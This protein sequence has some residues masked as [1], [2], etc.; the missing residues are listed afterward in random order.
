MNKRILIF[1]FNLIEIALALVIL[2]VGLSS[3]M[4]LFPV[5]MKASRAGVA[6]NNLADVAERVAAYVQS[7]YTSPEM[8]EKNGTFTNESKISTFNPEP[9][10]SPSSGDFGDTEADGVDGL[11]EKVDGTNTYFLYRQY[12]EAATGAD[13]DKRPID[14]EAIVRVGWDS[15]TLKEQ[16]YPDLAGTD[17][18]PQ[19]KD[20]SRTPA[21]GVEDLPTSPMDGKAAEAILNFCCRALIIEISWPA[22]VPWESRERRI[23][24]VEM[25]NENFVPYPQT[26]AS[27][28][29]GGGTNP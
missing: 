15:E 9:V 20:Y 26:T 7:K 23:F 18:P 28:G 1:R 10:G 5:G 13:D 17:P 27:G 14:F 8:W 22:D 11:I 2:A 24:R 6:D 3:V 16:Y 29:S 21:A 25:F 19:Y 12:S 4:V